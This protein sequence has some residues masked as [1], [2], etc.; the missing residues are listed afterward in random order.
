MSNANCARGAFFRSAH[1]ELERASGKFERVMIIVRDHSPSTMSSLRTPLTILWKMVISMEAKMPV[2]YMET[3][4]CGSEGHEDR[5]GCAPSIMTR[6]VGPY[7]GEQT[8][9][10]IKFLTASSL[11]DDMVAIIA[12]SKVQLHAATQRQRWDVCACNDKIEPAL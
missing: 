5:C 2:W 12:N 4:A 3:R 1:D 7:Y 9:H 11:E 6:P 10:I 8:S